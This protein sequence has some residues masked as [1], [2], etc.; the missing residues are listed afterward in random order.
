MS[1]GNTAVW[2]FSP[3]VE[4]RVSKQCVRLFVFLFQF[5]FSCVVVCQLVRVNQF[6]SFPG[7]QCPVYQIG[8]VSQFSF[9]FFLGGVSGFLFPILSVCLLSSVPGLQFL[10]CLLSWVQVSQFVRVGHFVNFPD[11]LGS[12]VPGC[13]CGSHLSVCN[14]LV[15][16]VFVCALLCQFVRLAVSFCFVCFCQCVTVSVCTV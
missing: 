1:H 15:L 12:S 13:Q 8:S 7:F 9:F 16:F 4:R 5:Q 10:V 3:A 14:F 2:S 6:V 11:F